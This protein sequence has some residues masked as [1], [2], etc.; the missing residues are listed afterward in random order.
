MFQ[1]AGTKCQNNK[2]AEYNIWDY[3]DVQEIRILPTRFIYE[4]GHTRGMAM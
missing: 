3:W 1:K 2:G 4:E